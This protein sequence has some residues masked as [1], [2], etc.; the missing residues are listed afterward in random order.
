MTVK[1]ILLISL[2]FGILFV[3]AC[4][5]QSSTTIEDTQTGCNEDGKVCSDGSVVGRVPPDCD[6]S[7]CPESES[8][9]SMEEND[10]KQ[11]KEFTVTGENYVLSPSTIRVKK[12]DRV[13]ITFENSEGFHD[14][15]IDEFDVATERISEGQ[16]ETVEFVADK[17][18]TFAYYCSVG[19]HRDSGMEG[20]LIVE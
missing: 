12:G 9:A 7:P 13:K 15:N 19:N 14:F 8:D 2:I 17:T 20:R 16:E 5:Q 18:G 3:S 11:V 6:F 10:V 1:T 4:A